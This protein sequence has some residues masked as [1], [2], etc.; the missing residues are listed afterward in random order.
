MQIEWRSRT[1]LVDEVAEVLRERI[2]AGH[3]AAGAPLRQETL[4]EDLKVS[5]TP[6]R[7]AIRVLEREG[8][9]QAEPGRGV[10]VVSADLPTVLEAYELREVVDGLAARLA[11][12]RTGGVPGLDALVEA[13]RATL[14]PFDPAAYTRTNVDFHA[15]IVEAAG[16]AFLRGEL[17]LV[18]LTSQVFTPFD[19][20]GEV[21]ARAAVDQHVAI[22]AAIAT[23]DGAT[24]EAA[25]RA[26][27]RST[28]NRLQGG[29]P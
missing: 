25:A 19:L 7:E 11:A 4:A 13:Q 28:I 12:E 9:L 10:R 24:A 5:R 22:V 15:A 23:G 8:L 3:Y 14:A 16:N 20:I 21:H 17:P 6:L 1:R 18:R 27:I 2:Y 26:H 29:D